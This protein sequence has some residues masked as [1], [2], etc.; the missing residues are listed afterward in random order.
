MRREVRPH[1][2]A[3]LALLMLCSLGSM[4]HARVS[5]RWGAGTQS[6][7]ALSTAGGKSAYAAD[8]SLNG[9][10]AELT[11]FSFASEP[12]ELISLLTRLFKGASFQYRGG[13]MAYAFLNEGDTVLRLIVLQVSEKAETLVIKI[14]QS[15]KEYEASKEPPKKHLIEEVPEFPGSKPVF[16]ARNKDTDF[17]IAS[18][19]A[20][21]APSD[22]QAF[23]ADALSAQGWNSPLEDSSSLQFYIR[24]SAVCMIMASKQERSG[25]S[26][27]TLLHKTHGVK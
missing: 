25:R 3:A 11:V 21:T 17:Q 26:S 7:K 13:R 24:G 19:T 14:E 8:I 10:D 20:L 18:S 15:A 9:A 23:Y 12:T 22:V 5:W 16:Y 6:S 1:L 2:S 27:I 4:S